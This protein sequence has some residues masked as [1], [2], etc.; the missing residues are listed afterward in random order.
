H[1]RFNRRNTMDTIFD[2]LIKRMVQN[3]PIRLK[4]DV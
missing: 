4:K 1:F 2:S 3:P